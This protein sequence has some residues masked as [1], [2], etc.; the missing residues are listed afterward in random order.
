VSLARLVKGRAGR[1]A[2]GKAALAGAPHGLGSTRSLSGDGDPPGSSSSASQRAPA[3]VGL[4]LVTPGPPLGL[5]GSMNEGQGTGCCSSSSSLVA[6]A[7]ELEAE[8]GQ[9]GET[10]GN[11]DLWLPGESLEPGTCTP[12]GWELRGPPELVIWWVACP[13]PSAATPDG[14]VPMGS[15]AAPQDYSSH[16]APWQQ[17][18]CKTLPFLARIFGLGRSVVFK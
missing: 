9:R 4:A 18:P 14:A 12:A 17:N 10:V 15:R 2:A 5:P 8:W 16:K 11:G 13:K 6:M 1:D 3:R 7:K